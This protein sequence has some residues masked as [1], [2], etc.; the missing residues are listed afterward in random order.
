MDP[1]EILVHIAAP[2]HGSDDARYRREALGISAF[3]PVKKH[4]VVRQK[5]GEVTN[6][7]RGASQNRSYAAGSQHSDVQDTIN[8]DG[9]ELRTHLI[10]GLTEWTQL[11]NSVT[12]NDSVPRQHLIDALLAW[13]TPTNPR[14]SPSVLVGRTPAP[15]KIHTS[16][17][18]HGN[19]L[20]E[21]TP[22]NDC[23]PRT[24]PSGPS[25]IHET[26]RLR[27]SFSDSFGTPLSFIPDSQLSK[28]S[29]SHGK[30]ALE[31]S[32]SPSPTQQEE[33][34]VKRRRVEEEEEDTDEGMEEII[35]PD[36]TSTPL[37]NHPPQDISSG[38]P[39]TQ[40]PEMPQQEEQGLASASVSWKD[41]QQALTPQYPSTH[42][43]RPSST[44]PQQRKSK[45]NAS[46][47]SHPRNASQTTPTLSP[48]NPPT[49][50]PSIPTNSPPPLPPAQRPP[51]TNTNTPL[52]TYRYRC[53]YPPGPP[54]TNPP[55]TPHTHQTPRL[56]ALRNT[57]PRVIASVVP[58]RPLGMWERGCW[59]FELVG[60]EWKREERE[61]MWAFL[62]KFVG[63]G[64]GGW[65]MLAVF[66]E[67]GRGGWDWS[68]VRSERNLAAAVADGGDGG[69]KDK[70]KADAGGVD[71][72]G[73]GGKGEVW[74]EGS[75]EGDRR[76]KV[77]C[78]GECVREVYVALWL[79]TGRRIKY[80]GARW[81]DQSGVVVVDMG[82]EEVMAPVLEN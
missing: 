45:A 37:L 10:N 59:Q 1:P 34:S 44:L 31:M 4:D 42:L 17:N 7:A 73:G 80:C 72:G 67:G 30:H 58:L 54:P 65:G 35:A 68:E 22:A 9:P 79:A 16:S 47:T 76:V 20:V 77:F 51:T 49:S 61:K 38:L 41:I 55:S 64:A 69:V 39:D 26:P 75:G 78:W 46:P 29:Q 19:L 62:E 12:S 8:S 28:A 43:S 15:L 74:G 63:G 52:S 32:S 11:E 5:N 21:R 81:V 48:M 27:R 13:T 70:Q 57:V 50:S 2:S 66:E 24:A 23:R 60:E 3:E 18:N 71:V 25:V 6:K 33:R 36:E 40:Q 53:T 56:L 14:P 82:R